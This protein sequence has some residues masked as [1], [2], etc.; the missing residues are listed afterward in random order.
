MKR[1]LSVLRGPLNVNDVFNF[2]F[3]KKNYLNSLNSEFF[4][5]NDGSFLRKRIQWV[6]DF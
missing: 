6:R 4:G 2:L 1:H 3:S 5:V